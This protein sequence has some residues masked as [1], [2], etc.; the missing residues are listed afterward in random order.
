MDRVKRR[1]LFM[2]ARQLKRN[3]SQWHWHLLGARCAFN[4]HKG[5]FA[6]VLEDSRSRTNYVCLFS[7]KPKREAKTLA[8]MAYGKGFM[9]KKGAGRHNPRFDAII[10][11]AKELSAQ[12]IE[13]HHHHLNPE[14]VFNYR[15]GKDCI[16]LED[17]VRKRTMV[18]VYKGKPMRDLTRLEKLFYS[19]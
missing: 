11:R 8:N 1:K 7:K 2:L 18:A 9:D 17:P 19:Q 14:C 5:R 15:K 3:G 10:R 6:I 4:R 16:I 13:W 12:G